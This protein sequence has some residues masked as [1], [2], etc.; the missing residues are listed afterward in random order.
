MPNGEDVLVENLLLKN[1]PYWT[2]WAPGSK[3]LEVRFTDISNRRH[4][5][6]DD[7]NIYDL[8]AFNTDGF[9]VT[10]DNVWIHDCT[11]WNQDDC[12]CVPTTLALTTVKQIKC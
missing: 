12:K 2:F 6:I 9:D 10:G 7:H 11:I 8:T 5:E 4:S 1:S 3:G